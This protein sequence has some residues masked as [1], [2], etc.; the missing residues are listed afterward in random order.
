M[1]ADLHHFNADLDLDLDFYL[2]GSGS[3][4]SLNT[5]PDPDHSPVLHQNYV[6]LP[7]LVYKTS[8]APLQGF[9]LAYTAL[10]GS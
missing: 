4:F 6:Y 7:P 3:D 2:C 1:V 10:H 5:D 8:R 9:I